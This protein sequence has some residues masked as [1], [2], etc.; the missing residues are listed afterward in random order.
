[1][2]YVIYQGWPNGGSLDP[3]WR[4]FELF[5]KL[6]NYMRNRRMISWVDLFCREHYD[7][8]TRIGK[9]GRP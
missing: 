3:C 2:Y 5:E 4:L 8:G 9:Q 6:K 7:F 1:M